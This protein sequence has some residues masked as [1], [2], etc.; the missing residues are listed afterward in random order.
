MEDDFDAYFDEELR[1]APKSLTQHLYHY[2]SA[3][4]AVFGILNSGSLRLSP[5]ESTNDLWES[6]P[7]YFSLS[8]HDDDVEVSRSQEVTALWEEID[9]HVRVNAKVACLTQD[10]ELPEQVMDRDALRGWAHL[11]LWAH[12]GG[13]HAGVCLRFDREQL[14]QALVAS[15]TGDA[16][17]FHGPVTYRSV[18]VGPGPHGI[19]IGQVREFGVDAVAIAYAA[20]H[21][22]SI[23]FRKHLDWANESEYR[24]VRLDQSPLHFDLRIESALTGVVLGDRFPEHRLPALLHVLSKYPNVEVFRTTFHNRRLH[25]WPFDQSPQLATGPARGW[26]GR[27]SGTLRER[28]SALDRAEVRAANL[29]AAAESSAGHIRTQILHDMSVLAEELRTWPSTQTE[30]RQGIDAI[31]TGQRSRRAGVPG[32]E[33]H[34]EAG[35]MIIVNA[36]PVGTHVFVSSAA[37]QVLADGEIR[38]HG[39]IR[40]ENYR[41]GA[42]HQS[43]HWRLVRQGPISSGASMWAEMHE[44]LSAAASGV[45]TQFDRERSGD[46]GGTDTTL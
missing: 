25:C 23:F 13:G 33:V 27:R 35:F 12:Y 17:V 20:R 45:H 22:P 21:A 16:Q 44:A 29:R 10:W 42:N 31:P 8:A 34:Y 5:F 14:A 2:T 39:A 46:S 43:E 28:I 38:L 6:R 40:T 32:E 30:M 26:A 36:L 1:L 24:L 4:A 19:D 41:A 7:T 3:E 15:S 9:R 18:S 11:S 37:L